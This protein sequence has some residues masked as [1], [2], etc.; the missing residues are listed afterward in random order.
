MSID[1]YYRTGFTIKRPVSTVDAG[2]SPIELFVDLTAVD[3]RMR[4][5]NGTEV[6]A[7]EALG[8]KTTDRFYCAVIDVEEKDRIY[9][10]VND[11]TYEIRSVNNVMEMDS[12]LQIDCELIKDASGSSLPTGYEYFITADGE[13]IYDAESKAVV[14]L[15]T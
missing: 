6:L 14:V 5:L 9:D 10:S 12:H 3:G 8:L 7:N 13:F 15:E 1:S 11:K 2:G 4:Q